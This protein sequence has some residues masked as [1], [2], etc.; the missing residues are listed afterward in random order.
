MTLTGTVEERTAALLAGQRGETEYD[1]KLYRSDIRGRE[2]EELGTVEGASVSLDNSREHTWELT[3]PMREAESLDIFGDWVKL[4][5]L[6]R[7]SHYPETT[8]PVTWNDAGAWEDLDV[9]WGDTSKK[10]VIVERWLR[11]PMGLYRFDF[12]RGS[13]SPLA[14]TYELTGKSP[15]NL[16][17]RDMAN[18][19]WRVNAGSYILQSVFDILIDKGI[20][21]NRIDF[22]V[23]NS[24]VTDVQLPT[25]AYF[26]PL[27]DAQGC[28]WLRICNTLLAAGGFYALYTDGEGRFTTQKIE[29]GPRAAT[30]V[31]YG[32]EP[33]TERLITEEIGFEYG[34][35]EFANRIVVYSGDP[36]LNPPIV[37]IA[38]NWD[39]DSRVSY[40]ALGYWVQPDPFVEQY[41]ANATEATRLAKARLRV[42]SG[43][44][45][46]L[47]VTTV[48]DPRRKPREL[49][50]LDVRREDGTRL[51]SGK[52]R[53]SGW[54][55]AL[56]LSAMSHDVIRE[57][58]L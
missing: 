20:P 3:V 15:E 25:T 44:D 26:D 22:P 52:W 46:K 48:P 38:E 27:Q 36:N 7:D 16:L 13:D 34:D 21:A 1:Y 4:V 40:D 50:T 30:D 51:W 11:F 54:T 41:I 23:M 58:R 5:V 47:S 37:G 6:L 55:L 12:P 39:P 32:S 9:S 53:V 14:R 17:L 28:Y 29:D 35:E 49:Y 2:I 31:T 8:G 19:G 45:L 42:A 43:V 57:V 33:G 24:V 56:D 18:Y 10:T